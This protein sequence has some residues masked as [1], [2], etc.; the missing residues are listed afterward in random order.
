LEKL[1]EE[2][3]TDKTIVSFLLDETGSMDSVRDKT[4]SGFNEYVATLKNTETPTLLRL[5]TFN[6]DGFNVVYDCEDIHSVADLTRESYRPRALTNLYDAIAKLVHDTEDYVKRISP[7]PR[8]MCTIMTDGEENS[9]SEYT[10]AAIFKLITDKEKE[11]WAFAYLGANQDAWAASESIG[12]HRRNS[13][14][15]QADAPDLALRS[16]ADATSRW[17]RR[18]RKAGKVERFFV[19]EDLVKIKGRSANKG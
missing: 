7:T 18:R 2:P 9:S 5:M 3:M 1:K 15:Y 11:G 6:T 14:N 16:T 17:V 8:V 19:E 10:R 13:A 4:V 12:I